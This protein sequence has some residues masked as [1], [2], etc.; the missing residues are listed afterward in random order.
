MNEHRNEDT[1]NNM[2]MGRLICR[3]LLIYIFIFVTTLYF[4][5]SLN[6]VTQLL[7]ANIQKIETELVKYKE[8]IQE[9]YRIRNFL[10]ILNNK[11]KIINVI[12]GWRDFSVR[13]LEQLTDL[14]IDDRMWFTR[15][16]ILGKNVNISGIAIDIKTVEDYMTRIE[17]TKLFSNVDL[18]KI[19]QQK[20]TN[21]NLIHT[22]FDI[23]CKIRARKKATAKTPKATKRK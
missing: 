21:K 3:F 6:R 11:L 8:T 22:N 1:E 17:K 23:S 10:K 14:L 5:G 12:S 4:N 18:T 2:S 15:L 9:V 13:V 19:K 16:E 7:N 20:Y